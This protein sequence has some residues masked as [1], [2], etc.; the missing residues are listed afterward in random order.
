MTVNGLEGR[1]TGRA[2]AAGAGAVAT[3]GVDRG[4]AVGAAAATATGRPGSGAAGPTRITPEHVA[5]LARTPPWGTLAGST[6]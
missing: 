3:T 6:R 1:R 5:H 2:A 4:G